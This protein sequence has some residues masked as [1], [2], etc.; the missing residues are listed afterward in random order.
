VAVGPI[1]IAPQPTTQNQDDGARLAFPGPD[2]QRMSHRVPHVDTYRPSCLIG[3]K[4][5][6]SIRLIPP[7][8][9]M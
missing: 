2:I 7:I 4:R 3:V 6:L 9:A 5:P 1:A 8:V